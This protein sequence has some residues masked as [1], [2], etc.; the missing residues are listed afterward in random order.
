MRKLNKP[1][2]DPG[3]VY[4][5]CISHVHD[6]VLKARLASV[7][8]NVTTAAINFDAAAAVA[9]LHQLHPQIDVG[10]IVTKEEMSKVYTQRMAKKGAPGRPCYDSLL[11][12]PAYGRCPLCGQGA[13]STLDHHLPKDQFPSLAVVPINLVP[14]CANC[15]KLK[16][17]AIPHTQEEQTLHP[18]FDDVEGEQWLFAELIQAA[19]PAIRFFVRPPDEWDA[20][21]ANRTKHHFQAFKLWAL[22]TSYAAEEL[23]NIRYSLEHLF[24]LSGPVGIKAHLQNQQETYRAAHL[25]SWQTAMYGALEQSDWFCEGGFSS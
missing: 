21:K 7:E 12:S 14:A 18:Y 25:N 1:T 11:A 2:Y 22:Y 16:T 23:T 4:L 20:I 19:P 10:G 6:P 15:N 9:M 5:T 8:P 24:P 13:V 3:Q 17:N